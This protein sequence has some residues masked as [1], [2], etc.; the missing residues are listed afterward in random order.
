VH[1][2][3]APYLNVGKNRGLDVEASAAYPVA[4]GHEG[5][6]AIDARLDVAQDLLELLAVDLIHQKR[7][8]HQFYKLRI[9]AAEMGFIYPP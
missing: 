3:N 1:L 2:T 8:F 9:N 5:G 7:R 4:A 6:A